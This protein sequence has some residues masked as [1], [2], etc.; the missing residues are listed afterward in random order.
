[1]MTLNDIKDIKPPVYFPSDYLPLVMIVVLCALAAAAFFVNNLIRKKIPE[2]PP[3]PK[4]TAYEI[5]CESLEALKAKG[6]IRLG[7]IKEYYVELSLIVRRYLENK[8]NIKAPEMT[9]EEFLDT[10]KQSDELSAGHKELLKIFL[11]HADMVKFAKY[12][13][14]VKEAEG[15]FLAAKT[16]IDET[17]AVVEEE[18]AK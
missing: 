12:G 2:K 17:S 5:A 16:L 3:I 14:N 15:S 4:K 1:M 6:L 13:P 10:A 18:P 7:K 8:F 11:S 9:T